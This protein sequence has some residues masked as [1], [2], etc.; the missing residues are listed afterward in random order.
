MLAGGLCH[1]SHAMGIYVFTRLVLYYLWFWLTL[2]FFS[3]EYRYFGFLCHRFLARPAR[4]IELTN[5]YTM[6]PATSLC[7]AIHKKRP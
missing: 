3:F 1:Y 2:I 6:F 4:L 7:V 5:L